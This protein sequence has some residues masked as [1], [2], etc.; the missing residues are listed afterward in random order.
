M[1][2]A[3]GKTVGRYLAMSLRISPGSKRGTRIIVRPDMTQ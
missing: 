2:G 3:P 1:V